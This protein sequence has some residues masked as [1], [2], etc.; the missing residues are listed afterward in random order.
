M[1]CEGGGDS[2][3]GDPKGRPWR[4]AS[5]SIGASMGNLEGGLINWGC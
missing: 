5:L 2:F 1:C 4:L 3:I